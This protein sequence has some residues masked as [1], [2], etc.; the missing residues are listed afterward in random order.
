VCDTYLHISLMSI[1]THLMLCYCPVSV[2]VCL[3][4]IGVLSKWLNI[5]M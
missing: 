3:S 5:V 2:S 4:Q 1:Y